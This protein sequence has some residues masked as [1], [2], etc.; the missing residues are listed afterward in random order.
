MK[1][2]IEL[3]EMGASGMPP[4]QGLTLEAFN[5]LFCLFLF[6]VFDDNGNE[7]LEMDEVQKAV[8]SAHPTRTRA[9]LPTLPPLR[10]PREPLQLGRTSLESGRLSTGLSHTSFSVPPDCASRDRRSTSRAASACPCTA[11]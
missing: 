6:H 9:A 5:R 7:V 3:F 10:P 11:Q 4:R 1:R 2:L 8:V